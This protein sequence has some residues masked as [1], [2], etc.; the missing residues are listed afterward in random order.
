MDPARPGFDLSDL[1]GF[2]HSGDGHL[3]IIIHTGANGYG[4]AEPNDGIDI[5][6]NGGEKQPGCQPMGLIT[7]VYKVVVCI[8]CCS[9]NTRQ[10]SCVWILWFV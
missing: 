7:A 2:I 4:I 6:P 10:N 1:N 3:V 5:Y 9:F 8:Q